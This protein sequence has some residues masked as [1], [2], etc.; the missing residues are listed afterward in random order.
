MLYCTLQASADAR[1]MKER[2]AS[3]LGVSL[4]LDKP[5]EEESSTMRDY[6]DSLRELQRAVSRSDVLLLLQTRNVLAE[7]SCVHCHWALHTTHP[8]PRA[9]H[10]CI[11]NA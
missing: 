8:L 7:P 9:C 2:L 10:Q 3:V 11:V 6:D 1:Y 4:F 5:N